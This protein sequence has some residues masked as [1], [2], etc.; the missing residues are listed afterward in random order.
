ME[1]EVLVF[2]GSLVKMHS[3]HVGA[4]TLRARNRATRVDRSRPPNP[5][6][7]IARDPPRLLEA[8][9]ALAAHAAREGRGAA[10]TSSQNGSPTQRELLNL[11]GLAVSSFSRALRLPVAPIVCLASN[12]PAA[13]APSS[14][15]RRPLIS[16][17]LGSFTSIAR[18][19]SGRPR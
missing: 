17:P 3:G 19:V 2:Q 12:P 18:F 14:A 5:S 15:D 9:A 7:A 6:R 10:P 4:F 8:D 16:L 11:A 1:E 13:P